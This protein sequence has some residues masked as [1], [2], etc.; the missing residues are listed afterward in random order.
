VP[1]FADLGTATYNLDLKSVERANT[2]G[3]K[4]IVAVH[5][6]GTP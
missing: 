4:A 3:T 6:A 1:V 5:L 2:A